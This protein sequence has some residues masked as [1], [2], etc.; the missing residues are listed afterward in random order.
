MRKALAGCLEEYGLEVCGEVGDEQALFELATRARPD[1]CLIDADLPA[2]SVRAAGK[3]R[4][5]VPGTSVLFLGGSVTEG[6]VA[7]AI[8]AGAVG[9]VPR[10][11][12]C[13]DVAR[14]VAIF[15]AGNG[16]FPHG[17]V[18]LSPRGRVA[19]T[20]RQSQV[21]GM[22]TRGAT[23]ADIARRLGISPVTARRHCAEIRRKLAAIDRRLVNA[24][25]DHPR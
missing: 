17:F 6:D 2:E 22:L 4:S 5:A 18:A 14:A 12:P 7:R 8:R 10:H 1:V 23:A 3:L 15:A 24:L 11:M 16:T 13:S 20:E 21:L 25:A 19:L 9:Y